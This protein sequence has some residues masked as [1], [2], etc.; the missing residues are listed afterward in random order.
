[1]DFL[2]EIYKKNCLKILVVNCKGLRDIYKKEN[3]FLNY[4]KVKVSILIF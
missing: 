4:L 3:I 2:G 1:M